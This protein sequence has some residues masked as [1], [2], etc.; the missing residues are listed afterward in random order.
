MSNQTIE[1]DA[2]DRICTVNPRGAQDAV[3]QFCPFCGEYVDDDVEDENGD[4]ESW[5]DGWRQAD[6]GE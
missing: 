3:I 4:T 5:P 2:C 1:C 6:E